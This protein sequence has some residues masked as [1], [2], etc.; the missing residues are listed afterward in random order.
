MSYPYPSYFD[1]YHLRYY[2]GANPYLNR[3]AIVFD[4]RVL[5]DETSLNR[6]IYLQEINRYFSDFNTEKI[7]SYA[8]LF[9][10]TVSF[11]SRLDMDLHLSCYNVVKEDQHYCI[12][13]ESLH[14]QT[15]QECVYFVLDWFEAIADDRY[16]NFER[17]FSRLK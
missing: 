5:V 7:N 13:M 1:I 14:H 6:E 4:L 9:A 12:A 8:D 2:S 16:L 17:H 15:L 3:K 10:Q 11:V